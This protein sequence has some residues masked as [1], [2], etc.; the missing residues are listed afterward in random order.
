[1][2]T[3]GGTAVLRLRVQRLIGVLAARDRH[4]CQ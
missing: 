2:A 3:Y 1:L 4:A